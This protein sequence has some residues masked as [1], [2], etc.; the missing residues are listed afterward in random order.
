MHW[1]VASS[2]PEGG[3]TAISTHHAGAGMDHRGRAHHA[4]ASRTPP[5]G[6]S[7]PPGTRHYPYPAANQDRRW[8]QELDEH[9]SAAVR[10]LGRV[11]VTSAGTRQFRA[12]PLIWQSDVGEASPVWHALAVTDD[13]VV[14]VVLTITDAER[15]KT[16][17]SVVRFVEIADVQA[18]SQ[19]LE[20]SVTIRLG[21]A[22]VTLPL[23]G[24][25]GTNSSQLPQ[26]ELTFVDVVTSR[27]AS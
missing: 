22:D 25:D 12:R 5:V 8:R 6:G 1:A 26:D 20:A 11:V 7:N 13:F 2:V 21:S 24:A 10:E 3:A 27:L 18:T 14:S 9:P 4:R 23:P 15:M 16:F 19:D 17:A